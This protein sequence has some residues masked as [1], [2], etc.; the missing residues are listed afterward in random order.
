MP[1]LRHSGVIAVLL[2]LLCGGALSQESPPYPDGPLEFLLNPVKDGFSVFS[3]GAEP[4]TEIVFKKEPEYSG[5]TVY[6]NAIRLDRSMSDFIGLACDMDAGTLYIDRNRNLDLTD[7]GP[8]LKT[9]ESYSP[10]YAQ[11]INVHLEQVHDNVPVQYVLDVYVFSDY[12]YS[13]VR[14]GWM[15]DIEI[16]GIPC[17]LGIADNLDGALG[18]GDEFRFDHERNWEARLSC[19]RRHAALAKMALV[20]GATLLCRKRF[21]VNGRPYCSLPWR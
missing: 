12:C 3:F 1:H 2:C 7:D 14:S 13:L 4:E 5:D 11:F 10:G 8:G 6:R 21:P 17:T 16:A 20:R 9:N 15:G 18:D 19:G